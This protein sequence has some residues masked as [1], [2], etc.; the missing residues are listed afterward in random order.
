MDEVTKVFRSRCLNCYETMSL[1]DS[2]V[3]Q[4]KCCAN[5]SRLHEVAMM[6]D[7]GYPGE[8]TICD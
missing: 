5:P 2:F 4:I 3:R 8:W 1:T 7:E 6:T